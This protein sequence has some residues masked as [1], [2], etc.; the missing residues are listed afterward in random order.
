MNQSNSIDQGSVKN[1]TTSQVLPAIFLLVALIAL[2]FLSA[3]VSPGWLTA[4]LSYFSLF[5]IVITALARVNDISTHMKG[6]RWH[7]R[8]FGLVLA[9]MGAAAM[10]IMSL[11]EHTFPSWHQVMFQ[12]GMALTWF[13][14][15]NMPPWWRYIAGKESSEPKGVGSPN[16]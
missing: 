4:A 10:V 14:T 16:G 12:F 8:R 15:P 5:I 11:A 7:T 2:Y 13:T 3:F 6:R 1:P 9:G